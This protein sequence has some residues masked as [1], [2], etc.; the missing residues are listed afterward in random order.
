MFFLGVDGEAF[1][2]LRVSSKDKNEEWKKYEKEMALY[3][4][5]MEDFRRTAS[6]HGHQVSEIFLC[7]TWR[8]NCFLNKYMYF[9][10]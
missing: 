3:G 4:I 6:V 8:E 2:I 1:P 7:I 5:T 9:F 10:Y